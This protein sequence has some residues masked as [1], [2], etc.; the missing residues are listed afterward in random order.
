M[1]T[2]LRAYG[3][4]LMLPGWIPSLLLLL[5]TM[6]HP[7]AGV[8]ALAAMAS[9]L[10]ARRWLPL[11]PGNVM[12]ELVNALL[13]GHLLAATYQ[14]GPA[15]LML[16]LSS[17]PLCVVTSMLMQNYVSR[18]L[19]APFVVVGLGQIA[20]ARALLLPLQTL[21][22]YSG[23]GWLCALGGI[24]L[25]PNPV[26][27]AMVGLAIAMGSTYLLLI[28]G[29]AYGV[30]FALLWS[31]GVPAQSFAHVLAGTQAILAAVMVGG[32]WLSPGR[33]SL[34]L[35]LLAAA[36]SSLAYLALT[37]LLAP[38][39]IGP[40]ALPFLL[41]TWLSLWVFWPRSSGFWKFQRM[42]QPTPPELNW[43]RST[44]AAARGLD[45]GSLALR[46]PFQETWQVYQGFDGPYTHQQEWRYALDFTQE[47]Q[48]RSYRNHGHQLDDFYCFGAPVLAP[49]A[50]VI[51]ATC[52]DCPD[53]EPGE[54]NLEQRWGNYLMIQSSAGHVVVLAH[55]KQGS[56][57]LAHGTSVSLGQEVAQCGNS[58][59]SPQPHLHMHVQW[60]TV[61]GSPTL[62]FHLTH[63]LRDQEFLLDCR[64]NKGDRLQGLPVRGELSLHFPVGRKFCYRIG[65][66]LRTFQVELDLLGQ[67]WLSSDR[68]AR[69]AFVETPEL[70][71]FYERT[72]ASDP[73][74]DAFT[75]ALGL[76]PLHNLEAHWNDR[77]PARLLGGWRPWRAN[78]CSRYHRTQEGRRWTQHGRH[79]TAQSWAVVDEVLGPIEFGIEYPNGRTLS[80]RLE[81]VGLL[82]DQGIPG[83]KL[84]LGPKAPTPA[85]NLVGAC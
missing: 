59:R 53:N 54:V 15:L 83:W 13:V 76:T 29:L 46:P 74:L 82:P 33:P 40:L 51:V 47:I 64:P 21:P 22:A 39:G 81:H 8:A 73:L 2:L 3:S 55:L 79:G 84:S 45:P 56:L 25:V 75:L 41:S 49:V 52:N 35:G 57:K 65:Q 68:G 31:L 38:F 7:L 18:P 44:L 24:F 12:L 58:G 43:E 4:F 70:V 11:G 16:I 27:G 71:A 69:V 85:P 72:G 19:C 42:T 6:V 1:K 17:G 37:N 61:L 78:L 66:Q 67:F 62:P 28:T 30:S 32:L 14:P 60:G 10:L 77:P 50:G 80:A 48:G 26:S 63:L 36:G 5:A 23:Y 9:A 34:V 20:V